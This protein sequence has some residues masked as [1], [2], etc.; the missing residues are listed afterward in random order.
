MNRLLSPFAI[1]VFVLFLLG[2][3]CSVPHGVRVGDGFL[4]KQLFFE[5]PSPHEAGA[6]MVTDIAPV[7]L[8]R[9]DQ[10]SVAFGFMGEVALV[11]SSTGRIHSVLKTKGIAPVPID[12]AGD[13]KPEVFCRGGGFSPVMLLEE[14][15]AVRWSFSGSYSGSLVATGGASADLDDDGS[16]EFYLTTN[17][18]L[19]CVNSDGETLWVERSDCH[20]YHVE[21][22]SPS[23]P[24]ERQIVASGRGPRHHQGF[25]EFRN[26]TG[27]LLKRISLKR[28]PVSFDLVSWPE[29]RNPLRIVRATGS[30]LWELSRGKIL[31]KD[32]DYDDHFTYNLPLGLDAGGLRAKA[33][34]LHLSDNE[35]PY[36]AILV[37]YKPTVGHSLLNLFTLGGE[38]V[39]QEVLPPTRGLLA[40]RLPGGDGEGLLVGDGP[41]RVA[42]YKREASTGRRIGDES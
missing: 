1:V 10:I 3:G 7:A 5:S 2:F 27:G 19:R 16:P 9:N 30:A 42:I 4:S 23:P 15:G 18:G 32:S 11:Q 24:L 37:F 6:W 20:Y 39:Y 8:G 38:L 22:F 28:G 36:L 13:G 34:L 31:V 35:K 25:I 26:S 40:I 17:K 12:L 14:T 33:T 41:G 21:I 29:E